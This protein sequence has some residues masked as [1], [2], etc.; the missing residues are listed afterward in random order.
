VDEYEKFNLA[1]GD[2]ANYKVRCDSVECG[3]VM[4]AYG[5]LDPINKKSS[6]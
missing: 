3:P 4:T 6:S 2:T 1:F 5:S